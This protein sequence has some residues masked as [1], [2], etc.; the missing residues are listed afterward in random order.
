MNTQDNGTK[1]KQGE[2][3]TEWLGEISYTVTGI[4]FLLVFL[5]FPLYVED[6]YQDMGT[7][8]WKFYLYATVPC[9]AVLLL[10]RLLGAVRK[11]FALA[12]AGSREGRCRKD[13]SICDFWVGCY[14]ICVLISFWF[15]GNREAAW[16]GADG[17][18]MGVAA[19]ELFVL[20]YF[21]ISRSEIPTVLFLGCNVAGSGICFLIGILQRLGFDLLNLY[22]G[23]PDV[24]LSNFLSTIGNRTWM[25]GYAC[26]V[27]P[28]GVCLFWRSGWQ[29]RT[30]SEGQAGGEAGNRS[31]HL[32][33]GF[34]SALA[35]MGLAA[36]YSDSAYVG[37]GAVF[38]LLG[39]FSLGSGR[40]LLSF[41][42]VLLLWF[43]SA[44][45]MCALRAIC[46]DRVRDA[47]GLT[48]Y[49][50]EW[51]WMLAGLLLCALVTGLV[52][53]KYFRKGNR[54]AEEPSARRIGRVRR[55][56]LVGAGILC[57]LLV[58]FVLL[59]TAGVLERL[60]HFTVRNRYLYFDEA[61]GDDRGWTWRMVCRMFMGLP[62]FQKLFGVGADC[63]AA[64]SYGR[65]DY[66]AQF[67]AFWEDAILTNAHNEWLNL[68]FCQG[69]VGGLAY[70]ASFVSVAVACLR[71]R[72]AD[73]GAVPGAET[74]SGAK[75]R[76]VTET[77]PGANTQG[78]TETSPGAGNDIGVI[79]AVGLCVAAYM[80][81]NFFC[82][83]QI[84]ATGPIFVLMGL[85]MALLRKEK[86]C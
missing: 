37:L 23:M 77:S 41:C 80:A 21:I 75:I 9:L 29:T 85:A 15:G 54:K 47:R 16:M 58:L 5:M 36:T 17:W 38:F 70:L 67:Y 18:Y 10:C 60:F 26:A 57:I 71:D 48:C 83:Q 50:Y 79:Q 4:Y 76:A 3:P 62:L 32:L 27:F 31:Q 73:A 34:Y 8:K 19:Q 78:V 61:W 69:I 40:K 65:P 25:S 72:T 45:F 6:W 68:F 11:R 81:H 82:Y 74:S 22:D 53:R 28:I 13:Y 1:E 55:R 12:G 14:G 2:K 49:V 46:G 43:G 35:F 39:V 44:L 56:C 86:A 42:Q 84:C 30:L 20:S 24:A 64:Y 52:Y 51:K 33:W 63:L 7:C 66:A 59:N